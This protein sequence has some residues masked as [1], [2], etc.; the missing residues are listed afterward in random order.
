M[1]PSTPWTPLGVCDL[2]LMMSPGQAYCADCLRLRSLYLQAVN[3]RD[4]LQDLEVSAVVTGR[5]F[6]LEKELELAQHR[7][8]E[9]RDAIRTHA[10]ICA[11]R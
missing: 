9:L 6:G 3:E 1:Q 4:H 5:E 11:L 8:D 7:Q 10:S 2:V